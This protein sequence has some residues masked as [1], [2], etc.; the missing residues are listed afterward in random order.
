MNG[1]VSHSMIVFRISEESPKI[2]ILELYSK[3][4][5]RNLVSGIIKI[6]N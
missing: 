6:E 3:L 2:N 1:S 4:E 5:L